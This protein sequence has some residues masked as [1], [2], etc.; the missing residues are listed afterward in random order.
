MSGKRQT[1]VSTESLTQR[2][3]DLHGLASPGVFSL[4]RPPPE[5]RGQAGNAEIH[6]RTSRVE[7][8]LF[9]NFAIGAEIT[10]LD[11]RGGV[12]QEMLK[13]TSV[14]PKSIAYSLAA[15]P[16]APRLRL[17]FLPTLAACL[18]QKRPSPKP[19]PSLELESTFSYPIKMI[20]SLIITAVLV[21][22]FV[23]NSLRFKPVAFSAAFNIDSKSRFRICFSRL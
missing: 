22:L 9:S 3:Q 23:Q 18:P 20:A 11:P 2:R 15:S 19:L 4:N 16:S 10:P 12:R 8:I 21:L 17:E 1:G 14:P 6:E 7:R 13:F 5:K